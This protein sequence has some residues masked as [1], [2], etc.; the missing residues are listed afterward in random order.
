MD[1]FTTSS[2]SP[3]MWQLL[4]IIYDT[5]CRDGFDFFSGPPTLTSFLPRDIL[6]LV[7]DN[8]P[9]SRDDGSYL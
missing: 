5:F 7:L 1:L 8:F 2:V 3:Q 9:P 4:P 6:L